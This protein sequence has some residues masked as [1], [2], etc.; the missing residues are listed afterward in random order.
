M[1]FRR[2]KQAAPSDPPPHGKSEVPSDRTVLGPD[3]RFKGRVYG[4]GHVMVQGTLEG[5]LD[6]QG[7][8]TLA[9]GGRL[10]GSL[11]SEEARIGGGFEGKLEGSRIVVLEETARVEG[12]VATPRIEMA[13]GARLNGRVDMDSPGKAARRAEP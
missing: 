2:R 9:S 12:E 4:K 3:W 6:L 10:K 7:T 8:V 11:R 5:E 13:A 1:F